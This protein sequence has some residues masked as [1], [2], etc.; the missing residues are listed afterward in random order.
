VVNF[1]EP[2]VPVGN[3]PHQ[4]QCIVVSH[5]GFDKLIL[6]AYADGGLE[7]DD[8]FS[9]WFVCLAAI[10]KQVSGH[11]GPDKVGHLSKSSLAG[12]LTP[13]SCRLQTFP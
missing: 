6:S 5:S 10:G 3:Y 7:R 13:S 8:P 11:C 2:G 12:T 9:A 4:L 1:S